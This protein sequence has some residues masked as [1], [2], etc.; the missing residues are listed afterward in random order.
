ML[1]YC[2]FFYDD[3]LGLSFA[4]IIIF[5]HGVEKSRILME[6]MNLRMKKVLK[7]IKVTVKVCLL[8]QH[9]LHSFVIVHLRV[10]LCN[11]CVVTLS[12]RIS[13]SG[14]HWAVDGLDTVKYLLF[15]SLL[16]RPPTLSEM[17][18]MAVVAFCTV[19]GFIIR[20][21]LALFHLIKQVFESFILFWSRNVNNWR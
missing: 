2:I 10:E 11:N 17:Q 16:W 18:F 20:G 19:C 12:F 4:I 13:C 14:W 3:M 6:V 8:S 1:K 5:W 21:F 15:I 7:C 9:H